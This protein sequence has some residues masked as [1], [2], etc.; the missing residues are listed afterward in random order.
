MCWTTTAAARADHCPLPMVSSPLTGHVTRLS[1]TRC[2]SGDYEQIKHKPS[3]LIVAQYGSPSFPGDDCDGFGDHYSAPACAGRSRPD[4]A[5]RE[6]EH[7]RHW[8]GWDGWSESAG[9]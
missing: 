6:S 8:R 5:E 2:S 7:R 9:A 3:I 1:I 4:S